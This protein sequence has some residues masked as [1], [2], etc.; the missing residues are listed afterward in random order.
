MREEGGGEGPI[1][2]DNLTNSDFL[3]LIE[4]GP[5]SKVHDVDLQ[6]GN[7]QGPR[8][9]GATGSAK[10]RSARQSKDSRERCNK[11]T[12]IPSSR[13]SLG[14]SKCSPHDNTVVNTRDTITIKALDVAP[15]TSS[16][17]GVESGNR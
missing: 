4:A 12:Y 6:K 10:S 11:V 15:N 2:S 1:H 13:N 17:W 9:R 8:A 5:N 14:S 7:K 16:R 3:F